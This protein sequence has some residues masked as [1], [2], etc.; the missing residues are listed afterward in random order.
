MKTTT[1]ILLALLMAS[2]VA[3]KAQ[4]QSPTPSASPAQACSSCKKQSDGRHA[5]LDSLS[6]PEKAQLKAA[7]QKVK[8]D[9]DFVS[10]KQAVKD[11]QTKEAK[12]AAHDKLN[13]VRHDLLLKADPTI[14]PVLDKIVA[15]KSAK[16]SK[17]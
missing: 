9:P 10:A 14:S 2:T 4:T 15:A 17:G 8:N 12:A 3:L 5:W 13:Q 11:A 1:A 7:M 6:D 16:P